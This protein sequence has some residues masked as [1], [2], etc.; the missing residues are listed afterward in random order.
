MIGFS[1]SPS[2]PIENFAETFK[3]KK[4]SLFYYVLC[5][6]YGPNGNLYIKI[7]NNDLSSKDYDSKRTLCVSLVSMDGVRNAE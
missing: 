3:K 2:L 1:L 5:K 6:L 4:E 7:F